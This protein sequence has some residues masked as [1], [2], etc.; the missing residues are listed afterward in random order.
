MDVWCL[1]VCVN[2]SPGGAGAD[3]VVSGDDAIR[4]GGGG[5]GLASP[6]QQGRFSVIAM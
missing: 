6:G 2:R 5:N 4:V 3:N 1:L